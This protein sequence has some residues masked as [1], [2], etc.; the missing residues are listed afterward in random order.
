[1]LS[2][3]I[4]KY[5]KIAFLTYYKVSWKFFKKEPSARIEH[6]INVFY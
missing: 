6:H 2:L 5:K 4:Y 3:I 1:M